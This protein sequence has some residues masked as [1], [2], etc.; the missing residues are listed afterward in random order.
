M[1]SKTTISY[2]TEAVLRY[3]G[4][5]DP[6]TPTVVLEGASSANGVPVHEQPS[7][8]PA[9]TLCSRCARPIGYG[10]ESTMHFTGEM[11]APTGAPVV[12][13]LCH[14]CA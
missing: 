7:A 5:Y 12:E 4:P 13:F 8:S 10:S 14:A 6:S 9:A 3:T 11:D 1:A 2:S